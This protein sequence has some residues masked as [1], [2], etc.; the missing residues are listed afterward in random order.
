MSKF[1]NIEKVE[2]FKEF[3]E[4]TS[5]RQNQ[6]NW[7]DFKSSSNILFLG[8]DY[9]CIGTFLQKDERKIT[10][11]EKDEIVFNKLKETIPNISKV[12]VWETSTSCATYYED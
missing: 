6:I 12:S 10:L 9:N 8:E 1:E 3:I 5:L 7:Y 4:N 11:L 2:K